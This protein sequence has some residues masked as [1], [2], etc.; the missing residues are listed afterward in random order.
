M[1]VY[2]EGVI[3]TAKLCKVEPGNVSHTH[4][5]TY[6]Q[7]KELIIGLKV[8]K[9]GATVGLYTSIKSKSWMDLQVEFET[10]FPLTKAQ[11]W[12]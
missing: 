5:T 4:L 8:K 7:R 2:I 1:S 12:P 3:G 10:E 9:L 6:V 11:V